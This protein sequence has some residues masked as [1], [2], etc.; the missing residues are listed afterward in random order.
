[1]TDMA[2]CVC[3][4]AHALFNTDIDIQQYILLQQVVSASSGQEPI[5]I[6]PY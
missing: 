1:M 6:T 4:H 2:V 3:V 5:Q